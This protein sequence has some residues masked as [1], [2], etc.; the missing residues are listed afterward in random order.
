MRFQIKFGM[1]EGGEAITQHVTRNTFNAPITQH[2]TPNTLAP[3]KPQQYMAGEK[4][5]G[6][7]SDIWKYLGVLRRGFMELW[8]LLV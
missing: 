3:A 2:P 5:S 4:N 1:T 8:Y 6:A 7:L